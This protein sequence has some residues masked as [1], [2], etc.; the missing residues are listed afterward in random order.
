[1]VPYSPQQNGVAERK[2]RSILNMARCMLKAKHL[3]KEFWAEAMSCAIY[4]SNSSKTKAVWDQTP[5]EA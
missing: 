1:M 3:P 4:L 2:N 5:Q